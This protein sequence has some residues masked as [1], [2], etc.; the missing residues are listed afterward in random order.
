LSDRNICLPPKPAVTDF[1][2][3]LP[4]GIADRIPAKFLGEDC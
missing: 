2:P 4:L 3:F 1:D